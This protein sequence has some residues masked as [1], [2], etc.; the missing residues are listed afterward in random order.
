MVYTV[1]SFIYATDQIFA[2]SYLWQKPEAMRNQ[3]KTVGT[4]LE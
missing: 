4:H 2:E 1:M 3:T